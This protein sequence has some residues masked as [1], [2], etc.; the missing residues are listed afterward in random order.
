MKQHIK[1]TKISL[2]YLSVPY[3]GLVTHNKKEAMKWLLTVSSASFFMER[4]D[5]L[6]HVQSVL[7]IGLKLFFF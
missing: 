4:L 1:V 3:V 7:T 5:L 2:T 6:S